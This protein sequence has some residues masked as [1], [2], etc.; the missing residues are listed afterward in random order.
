M[1]P[2]SS[3][4]SGTPRGLAA[5][6][7]T[8]A[9]ERPDNTMRLL[10]TTI[11]NHVPE[12]QTMN[13]AQRIY[14][15]HRLFQAHNRPI[16]RSRIQKELEC[17]QAT[18]KR[19]IAE[20][21]DLLGA[22][23][24]FDRKSGGY[25]YDQAA[26]AFELPGFWFNE[27]ELYAVLAAIQFLEST[28][29][30][31]LQRPLQELLKRLRL[32]VQDLGVSVEDL[33][34]R[35]LLHPMRPRP[36]HPPIFEAL[37]AGLLGSRKLRLLYHGP[38]KQAPSPRTIHPFRLL[39]Y[40]DA[41]YLLAHCDRADDRRTFALDRILEAQVLPEQA[42]MPN[43]TVLDAL[44]HD[45][46]GIFLRTPERT[47]TLRFTGQAAHWVKSEVWHPE[48]IGAWRDHAYELRVPYGDQRELVMEIL[49]YG[50]DVE[51]LAPENLRLAVRERVLAAAK[52]YS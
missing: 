47:A 20:M 32:V 52:K 41:W 48:Q 14:A 38:D 8:T 4:V 43:N 1:P 40:R 29:P 49:K 22:P 46:F 42:N 23:I 31:L 17:S 25:R 5:F 33:S 13:R 51:V 39:H 27:S 7:L 24:V 6:A 34:R 50:P 44:M 26:S 3:P 11:I 16:P 10:I 18:V 30:G 9:L 28:Q 36:V 12:R 37:A 15:L 19:I 45:S 21:R 35:V 2:A